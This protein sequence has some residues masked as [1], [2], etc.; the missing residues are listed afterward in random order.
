M[1]LFSG[2]KLEKLTISYETAKDTFT[3]GANNISV[4]FNPSSLAFQKSPTWVPVNAA[5]VST[6]GRGAR[7][8]YKNTVPETLT[9]SLFFDTYELSGAEQ[10]LLSNLNVT[11]NPFSEGPDPISV[12]R[13]T[14]AVERLAD[15]GP[16]LHRPPVCKLSWGE[17]Q[18]PLI[19]PLLPGLTRKLG[20]FKGVLTSL[21]T[22]L[23]FFHP[24]GTPLRATLACVFS[25][26]DY[27]DELHSADVDKHYVVQPRDTLL[28]IAANLYKDSSRWRV[29]AQANGIDNPRALTPGQLLAI[30][31]IS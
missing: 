17:W 22:T 15:V 23:D 11:L 12:L 20:G 5:M 8:Q 6:T 16:E 26:I 19:G 2:P 3:S 9:I 21:G 18:A 14:Q 4:L 24:N 10:S 27:T 25:D 28:A 13:Y 1:S 7:M 31:K 30:P 29:I